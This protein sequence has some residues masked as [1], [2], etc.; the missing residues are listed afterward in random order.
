M[1]VQ[2][3]ELYCTQGQLV[4]EREY[5]VCLTHA[6]QSVMNSSCT[7]CFLVLKL[8]SFRLTI[9]LI[10]EAAIPVD[11][12][13]VIRVMYVA[14][15]PGPSQMLSC[16]RGEKSGE[17]LGSKLHHGPE[18]VDSVSTNQVHITY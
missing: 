1:Q 5:L 7:K 3:P 15:F 16:S 6:A 18:M 4:E 17:D 13:R 14:S 8:T 10:L 9:L 2:I 12:D 11:K